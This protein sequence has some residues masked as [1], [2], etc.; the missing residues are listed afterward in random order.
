MSY[1]LLLFILFFSPSAFLKSYSAEEMLLYKKINDYRMSQGL[2]DLQLC[3]S[4]SY[5][6]E[7][8]SMNIH[9]YHDFFNKECAFHSWYPEPNAKWSSGCYEKDHNIMYSKPKEILGMKL[10]GYEIAHMH[11]LKD[12]ECSASCSF[13]GWLNSSP[14]NAAMLEK[15]RKPTFKRMGVSIYKNVATVWFTDK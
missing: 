5:V 4:M 3:D 15:G 13:K 7:T 2:K 12:S 14:H 1:G 9:Q 11:S 10:K 8:H 6:A